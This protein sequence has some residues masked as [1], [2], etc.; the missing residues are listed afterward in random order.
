MELKDYFEPYDVKGLL[1]EKGE[2]GKKVSAFSEEKDFSPN[3]ID[4][5]IIGVPFSGIDLKPTN[6]PT[7]IRNQLY[8]LA[9]ILPV[10]FKILDLG[11]IKKGSTFNDTLIGIRDI[12]DYI[13]SH[14]IFTLVLGGTG[15]LKSALIQALFAKGNQIEYTAI[16]PF[17]SIFNE[18]EMLPAQVKNFFFYNLI[19]SQ[20][21]YMKPMYAKWLKEKHFNHYRLGEVR[22]NI[23]IVEPIIRDSDFCTISLNALKHADAPGQ[24]NAY[25]NGF[26]GEEISQIARFI[27][28]SETIKL[29]G[30]FDYYTDH[31]LNMQTSQLAAQLLWF[32]IEGYSNRIVEDVLTDNDIQKFI[33]NHTDNSYELIFYKSEKTGRWWM[34]VPSQSLQNTQIIACSYEDYKQA[35]EHSVPVRWIRAFQKYNS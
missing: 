25:P 33:V 26:Y 17:P 1:C 29:F 10:K 3:E 8:K 27:G 5:A 19:G 35:S 30:L 32:V 13:M 12:L 11:N 21:Y 18:L 23:S 20:S 2:I 31:D 6:A 7:E 16:E 28:L 15:L 34:E 9:D 24:E 14:N 22:E 4:I